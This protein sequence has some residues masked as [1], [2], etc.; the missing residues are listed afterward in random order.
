[1]AG[2]AETGPDRAGICFAADVVAQEAGG[3]GM[4]GV[5]RGAGVEAELVFEVALDGAGV[6]EAGQALGEGR[7]LWAGGQ[8]DGQPPGGDVVDGAA[9]GIG[10]RGALVDEPLVQG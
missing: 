2:G 8:P 9:L 4:I 5:A 6:D 3:L 10:D 1:V 7:L